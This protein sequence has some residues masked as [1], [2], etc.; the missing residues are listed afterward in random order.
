MEAREQ[1]NK[2]TL[3]RRPI[4][5]EEV[6][7]HK[8]KFW[9]YTSTDSNSFSVYDMKCQNGIESAYRI[10]LKN[11]RPTQHK[12]R[13]LNREYTIDFEKMTQLNSQSKKSRPVHRVFI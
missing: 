10:F 1:V 12:L 3:N 4:R 5:I 13:L 2:G 9:W 11:K 8:P 7:G 6:V